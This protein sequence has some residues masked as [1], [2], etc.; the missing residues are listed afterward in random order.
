MAIIMASGNMFINGLIERS[1]TVCPIVDPTASVQISDALINVYRGAIDSMINQLGKNLFINFPPIV[2]PCVNCF[3]DS[4]RRRSTGIY[5][6]GGPRPFKRG[7][8]CPW[9]KGRGFQETQSK[10]CIKALTQ[11][12]P[13]DM[14][15][16]GIDLSADKDVVRIKTLA[17]YSDDLV[18]AQ[19]IVP[20]HDI[21]NIIN[22]ECSLLKGPILIGLRSSRYCVSFW[23]RTS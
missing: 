19:T 23:R 22:L 1:E 18:R 20:N 5:I 13:K 9:C 3:F 17:I 7:R 10:K 21:A 12:N 15:N 2:E 11:W 4:V 6:S 8:Q 16:Y 14:R